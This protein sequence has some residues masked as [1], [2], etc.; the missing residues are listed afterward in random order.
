MEQ[1]TFLLEVARETG[2]DGWTSDRLI[3]GVLEEPLETLAH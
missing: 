2:V 1:E 3:Y